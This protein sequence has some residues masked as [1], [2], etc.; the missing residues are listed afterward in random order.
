MAQQTDIMK[1]FK[2]DGA[3]QIELTVS[4]Q[5]NN[6][7]Q[8]EK[9][10]IGAQGY[11]VRDFGDIG[12]YKLDSNGKPLV[13]D[14]ENTAMNDSP[15]IQQALNRCK[16]EGGGVVF[17]PKG[18]YAIQ[19]VLCV[20]SNTTV[21]MHPQARIYRNKGMIGAFFT[22]GDIGASYT[23]YDG[24][25]NIKF[26]GG[27]LDGNIQNFD[28]RFNFF[29]IGHARNI[30]FD[31][32]YMKD[33][34]T[35]HAIEMNSTQKGVIQ[36]CIFDGWTLDSTFAVTTPDRRS[37]AVQFDGMYSIDVFGRFGAYDKTTCDDCVVQNCSFFNWNRGVGSHT[38]ETDYHHK[39]IRVISN[40][41]ENISDIAVVTCMWE[42][43]VISDN[44][45]YDCGG[46]IWI[47]VKDSTSPTFG[48][49]VD[50]NTFRRITLGTST[51]HAIRVS[52]L[53]G[54]DKNVRSVVISNNTV[55]S[56]ADTGFYIEGCWRVSITGNV[57]NSTGGGH[58]IALYSCGFG[59]I[60]GNIVVTT[61]LVGIRLES[62]PLFTVVGNSVSNCT[63]HGIHILS[64]SYSCTVT[65]NMTRNCNSGGGSNHG[66][67]VTSGSNNVAV[68]SNVNQGTDVESGT[69]ITSGC[70]SCTSIGNIGGGKGHY[71]GG[72]GGV[73]ANNID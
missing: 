58:G 36:N 28:D 3:D 14:A 55:E 17:F 63:T 71:N 66:V 15:A 10:F 6:W 25:S 64:D 57:I 51:R 68:S 18:N 11:N 39:N 33:C 7:E 61:G 69:Y 37:E 48:Y 49:V 41:F 43:A 38:S 2:W 20:Y 22:N 35:Y 13:G 46:G 60:T 59:T 50:G 24:Q 62:S 53:S 19:D 1:F 56:T 4:E 70:S 32:V 8:L 73:T 52:G 67:Y 54:T 23:G 44:T 27:Y 26:I 45:F 31:G 12:N 34:Q 72:T 42:G 65:S 29:S 16:N 47:R 40:H 30:L 5:S 21:L 9:Y